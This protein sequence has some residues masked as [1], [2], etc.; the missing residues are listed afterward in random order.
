MEQAGK[1]NFWAPLPFPSPLAERGDWSANGGEVG[2]RKYLLL[3]FTDE[4]VLNNLTE[5]E[6]KITKWIEEKKKQE[7]W[8]TIPHSS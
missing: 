5:V 3:H 4:E 8:R 7:I 2:E 6:E 1:Q